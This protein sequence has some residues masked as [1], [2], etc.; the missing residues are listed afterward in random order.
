MPDAAIFDLDRTLIAGGT[1]RVFQRHLREA[2]VGP[3][4]EL[5]LGRA[6][7]RL[8]E[9]AGENPL[10]MQFLRLGVRATRGWPVDAV[11]AAAEKAADELV[12][13]MPAYARLTIDEHRDAG[14]M[15]VLATTTP[16][17]LV[18][19][20]ADRLGFDGVVATR[21]AREADEYAGRLDGPFVWGRGKLGA[22]RAWAVA[23]GVDLRRCW[24]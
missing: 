23:V 4:R 8:F 3:D 21:W 14:R 13:A 19:P 12:E 6:L 11:R 17:D 16:L 5:P 9:V 22:V 2:G 15:V 1:G 24:A 10:S 20:L 7:Y 18:G